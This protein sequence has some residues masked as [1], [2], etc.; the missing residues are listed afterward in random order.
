MDVNR[1]DEP[2]GSRH[3]CAEQIR[4]SKKQLETAFDSLADAICIIGPDY[5]IIRVNRSYARE[6]GKPIKDLLGLK[7]H[8]T[9]FARDT[10]CANCPAKRVFAGKSHG[11]RVMEA[12]A[13]ADRL[14]RKYAVQAYPVRDVNNETECVIEHFRDITEETR[15]NEQLIRSE[16]LASIGIMTAGIAHEMNNPLSGLSGIAVNMLK[17]PEKYGLNEK[18]QERIALILE[19]AARATLV[20]SD[21]LKLSQRQEHVRIPAYFP[22]LIRRAVQSVRIPGAGSFETSVRIE[23]PMAAVRC[24]P[25]R[26][27]QAIANIV[28]NGYQALLQKKKESD[29]PLFS[30]RLK[31]DAWRSGEDVVIEIADNGAGIPRGMESRI[32]DPFFTTRAPG[33]GAG[34]G[35]SL[36]H[37]IVEEHQGAISAETADGIT[38][39]RLSLPIGKD[40]LAD[41]EARILTRKKKHSHA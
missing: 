34:L 3:R 39:V 2:V 23:E 38:R 15:M 41:V 33:K 19:A 22:D 11:T 28:T 24:D 21:L 12:A 1:S 5:R 18:G 36:C 27:E 30:G 20:M 6:V 31:I 40:P 10:V 8:E 29:A 26:I 17:M 32:F 16:K 13:G 25:P 9:F 35:L 37:R 7:C 14:A 4:L